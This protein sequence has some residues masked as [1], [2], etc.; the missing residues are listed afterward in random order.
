MQSNGK[1]MRLRVCT[2]NVGNAPPPSDLSA[3]LGTDGAPYDIIAVGAQEANFRE[4]DPSYASSAAISPHANDSGQGVSVFS[5]TTST[6]KLRKLGKVLRPAAVKNKVA[7]KGTNATEDIASSRA[8]DSRRRSEALNTAGPLESRS[9]QIGLQKMQT[10]GSESSSSSLRFAEFAYNSD[11]IHRLNAGE[12]F[13]QTDVD[14]MLF[15]PRLFHDESDLSLGSRG[16]IGSHPRRPD[17]PKSSLRSSLGNRLAMLDMSKIEDE[18][19][20]PV[21]DSSE[22]LTDEGS[23]DNNTDT[24]DSDEE[25]VQSCIPFS[26]VSPEGD[27]IF[28]NP[29]QARPE[30]LQGIGVRGHSTTL[31]CAFSTS[32]LESILR[33]QGIDTNLDEN[34]NRRNT[35]DSSFPSMDPPIANPA[36]ACRKF[37]KCVQQAVGREYLLVA[38]HHLMEIK[39]LLFVHRKHRTRIGK[40]EST[41]EAT[42]IGNV[43]GNK[44]AVA[45]KLVL[46]DTTFCFVSSHLA[47]HEG[48]KFLQQRNADVEEI[49][50]NLERTG[51][52]KT[53]ALPSIHQ[54]SHIVWMGDLN[55]RLDLERGLPKAILLSHEEKWDLVHE[56]IL[57]KDVKY[58]VQYDELRMEMEKMSVFANFREGEIQFLPT[59]KVTRGSNEFRYQRLRI[60]SYCDRILWHSLPMHMDKISLLEY[61]AMESYSTS[62]H[63]PVYAVFELEIPRRLHRFGK[64]IPKSALKCTIDF[65]SLRLSGLY[66]K[67]NGTAQLDDNYDILEDGALSLKF[68]DAMFDGAALLD[69]SSP[70]TGQR[71]AG[72]TLDKTSS[73]ILNSKTPRAKARSGFLQAIPA[74]PYAGEGAV[75]EKKSHTRRGVRVEFHG[76]GIFLRNKVFPTDVPLKNGCVRECTY[77]ELPAIPLVPLEELSD[78][79]HRHVT[80]VFTRWGS[81]IASSCVLPIAD[82]LT[83]LGQHKVKTRLELTKFGAPIAFV[84]VEAE[85]CISM[86][87]WIDSR[88]CTVKGGHGK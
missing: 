30:A 79:M 6:R 4:A 52:T 81:K 18:E 74:D 73:P 31:D 58:L 34:V 23:D 20:V 38:K 44:G 26:P 80:I 70:S 54:F 16:G 35:V 27:D 28:L 78:L 1:R 56:A 63:K 8:R 82:M 43:V 67:K 83:N 55:Y 36:S 40:T 9:S 64:Q 86:E 53:S 84:E 19:V 61:N 7:G 77:F 42:G 51:P 76:N 32:D 88:N 75:S 12:S 50:R 71:Q 87:T 72:S 17:Q 21:I 41:S 24:G 68:D 62:D 46:D 22:L 69:S 49:M 48:T 2:W 60:P 11:S 66:E 39:L 14:L 59:F 15:A 57:R 5:R 47:A 33:G 37:S 3:W 10:D 25:L 65:Q 13:T 85:L 45:V 29:A